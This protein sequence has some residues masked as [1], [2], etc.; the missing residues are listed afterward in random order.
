M[1]PLTLRV[2]AFRG[3]R[4]PASID[5]GTPITLLV[6]E[7]RSG[8]SSTTNAIEWCLYGSAVE[9]KSPGL[10]ER[11]EWEVRPRGAGDLDTVVTL[12][13]E[14]E[15]GTVEIER[16]RPAKAKGRDPDRLVVRREGEPPLEDDAAKRWLRGSALPSWEDYRRAHCFHQ[17][18]AR[19]R[20]IDTKDRSS[21]LAA[22]LGL[23]EDLRVRDAI[24]DQTR[25]SLI[26]EVDAILTSVEQSLKDRLARPERDLLAAERGLATLG[27]E[28]AALG[29]DLLRASRRG[30]VD[31]ARDLAE[32]LGIRVDLPDPEDAE[33]VRTW[34]LAWSKAA[35]SAAPAL[36][37]LPSLRTTRG[38]LDT[39]AR[40]ARPA[41]DV[42]RAVR[43]RL[44]KA[45]E[46][47]GDLEVRTARLR[48][49]EAVLERAE[50]ER[51]RVGR[52]T[53][54]LEDARALVPETEGTS[55]CPV[56]RTE[57]DGIAARI[58]DALSGLGSS[59]ATRAA[60][61]RK[62]AHARCQQARDEIEALSTLARDERTT[63]DD[64]E[65]KRRTLASLLAGDPAGEASDLVATAATRL[66]EIDREGKALA[67]LQD[68]R[69]D[70]LARHV[71]EAD[72]LRELERWDRLRLAA[73]RVVDL[74]ALAAKPLLDTAVD[75]A[76]AFAADV[77]ALANLAREAQEDRSASREA[78]VNERL[79]AY[80]ALITGDAAEGVRVRVH[81]TAKRL[82]YKLVDGGGKPAVPVLN[83]AALNALSLAML[84][85]QT[86]RRA[87]RGGPA[88]GVLDD[89]VQSLDDE[90]QRG[91]ARA[92]EKLAETCAVVVA[93]TPSRF[94]EQVRDKVGTER[95]LHHLAPWDP[96]R[97]SRIERTEAL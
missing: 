72:L 58:D 2:Q 35:R 64:H 69:D 17:E 5:L 93:V 6:G 16:L 44:A 36:A 48:E 45:T 61:A 32:R 91:L 7:N 38:Q 83:Q 60:E 8:K 26:K 33:A 56:C 41:Q 86:E 24:Q 46:E 49:A 22:L 66:E 68:E 27:V 34:A 10:E 90:R 63:R 80:Y 30:L 94:V 78:D 84:L 89:P 18:A 31:G 65:A 77:E 13:L 50:T 23:E 88:F 4:G 37:R 82:T 87:R 54:L 62:D 51:K 73:E 79:G 81:R 40:M 42:W 21:V 92:V 76:A 74:D 9:R 71:Q 47:G 70:A 96:A 43:D 57:V 20:V 53:A 3:W 28:R 25:T 29:G 85:A 75:A 19:T 15:R 12:V 97:G 67:A 55:A 14:D 39:A 59:E 52:L 1:R 11:A 95:R